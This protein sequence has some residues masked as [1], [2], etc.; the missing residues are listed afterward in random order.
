MLQLHKTALLIA[1]IRQ[2]LPACPAT[3]SATLQHD[4]KGGG[5]NHAPTAR[6]SFHDLD[7]GFQDVPG[8]CAG[9]R[10]A[11]RLIH[12]LDIKTIFGP[13]GEYVGRPAGARIVYRRNPALSSP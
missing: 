10:S 5:G 4:R 7:T 3:H 8:M 9:I 2:K 1:A 12:R 13:K 11:V 6:Q